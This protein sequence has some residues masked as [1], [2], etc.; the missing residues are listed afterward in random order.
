MGRALDLARRGI[1]LA[2]PNPVVG[3]VVV[4]PSGAVVG[5]GWHEGPGTPHAERVA[6]RQAG[7]RAGGGALYVTL[8][9]CNHHGRTPPCAPAVVAAGIA[10]VVASIADPN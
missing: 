1:G 7:A 8:E 5:E 4:D 10:R 9:P 2:S 6:L 3:A